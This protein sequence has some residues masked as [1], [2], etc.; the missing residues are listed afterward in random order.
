[1]FVVAKKQRSR[2]SNFYSKILYDL[3]DSVPNTRECKSS[4]EMRAA[5][6]HFNDTVD[7][8]TGKK[9]R[10]FS[11]DVKSLYPSLRKTVCKDAVMWLVDKCNIKVQSVDW[12]QVTRY[13]AIHVSPEEI[14]MEGL[15]GVIPLRAK[16]SKDS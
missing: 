5:F 7:E 3:A 4:E 13:V 9:V 10:I 2:F 6:E 1:M 11:M 12:V 14:S 15:T 16:Q 8:E